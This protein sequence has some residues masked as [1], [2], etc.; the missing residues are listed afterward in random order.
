MDSSKI[1]VSGLSAGGFMAVQMHVAYSGI[2]AGVG[3]LA[4][5]S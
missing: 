2:F 1:S 5:G 4:G 3:V